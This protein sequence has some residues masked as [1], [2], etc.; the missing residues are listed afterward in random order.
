M[1]LVNSG[2]YRF[3]LNSVPGS[4]RESLHLM[5][6]D[7][8]DQDTAGPADFRIS[9]RTDSW[10]RR[11]VRP[12]ITFYSDQHAP[13]K[14]VPRSQ[15]MPILEWGMNWCVAA[16]DYTRLIIHAA[17]IA[18]EGRALI[19]P[20]VP[21][22]GKSTL[23]AHL[24]LS[25]WNLYSDEMAII[26]G[27]DL[28]VAPLFRPV[29]LKNDS[30]GLVRNWFPDAVMT[31]TARDTRKGDIA[32]LK[33]MDWQR[34]TSLGQAKIQGVIFP[35][36]QQGARFLAREMDSLATFRQLCTHAFNYNILGE[37]GFQVIARLVENS[38][39]Y[40]L[41]YSDV[42]DVGRFISEEFFA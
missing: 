5:Y 38:R 1:L 19:F 3:R 33:A 25:G 30:I 4:V 6:G 20:A 7:Q 17:V 21:G 12:Q 39:H 9:L 34:F 28:T 11:I 27:D 13:F 14:P 22:S 2:R 10:L 35:K 15:A 16:H 40:S 29:C 31:R 37:T 36:F 8:A 24:A 42:G 18:K 23:A 41:L 32:H 26:D